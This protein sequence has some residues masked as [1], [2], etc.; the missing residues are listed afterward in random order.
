MTK[1]DMNAPAALYLGSDWDNARAQGARAFPSAANAIRFAMEQAAPVS[2]RGALMI[3]Q[4][5]QFDGDAI[6]HLYRA[7][8]Y[9][10]ARKSLR[11][12]EPSAIARRVAA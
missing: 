2:L 1:I 3:V 4:D 7:R 6:A 10:F 11:R 12:F 9:P 5:R 8:D